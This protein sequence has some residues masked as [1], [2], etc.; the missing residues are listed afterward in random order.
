ME[1]YIDALQLT[2]IALMALLL[3]SFCFVGLSWGLK[4][5]AGVGRR[6]KGGPK[7]ARRKAIIAAA[8]KSYLDRSGKR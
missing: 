1:G 4:W 5:G 6:V 8:V 7:E 3:I 2:V